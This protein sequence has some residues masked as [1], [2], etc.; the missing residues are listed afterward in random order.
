MSLELRKRHT[1][2]GRYEKSE[3]RQKVYGLCG[4][5]GF[6]GFSVTCRIRSKNT[7]SQDIPLGLKYCIKCKC[8]TVIDSSLKIVNKDGNELL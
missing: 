2:S 4:L 6:Y 3:R 8:V 5:C 7:Q 1:V